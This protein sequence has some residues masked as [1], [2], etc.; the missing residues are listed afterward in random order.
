VKNYGLEFQ[1][2]DAIHKNIALLSHAVGMR[3]AYNFDCPVYYFGGGQAHLM[4]SYSKNIIVTTVQPAFENALVGL[5][6]TAFLDVYVYIDGFHSI[7]PVSGGLRSAAAGC[8]GATDG[9]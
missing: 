5:A 9:G 8:L 4:G 6:F 3:L 2:L 7:S 1:F